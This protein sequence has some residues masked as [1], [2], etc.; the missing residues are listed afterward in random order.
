MC[1]CV[2]VCACLTVVYLDGDVNHLGT[3]EGGA[4]G[5]RCDRQAADTKKI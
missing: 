1:V 2:C 4:T 3:L 5:S